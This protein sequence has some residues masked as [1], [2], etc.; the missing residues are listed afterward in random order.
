MIG[1]RLAS[2]TARLVTT[3]ALGALV[4]SPVGCAGGSWLEK[5][6]E[7]DLLIDP[8]SHGYPTAVRTNP[9]VNAKLAATVQPESLP[10]AAA[11]Q[12][13]AANTQTATT[14][15]RSRLDLPPS[16][17]TALAVIPPQLVNRPHDLPTAAHVAETIPHPTDSGLRSA[18][19]SPWL[20]VDS[21]ASFP[22]ASFNPSVT[23]PVLPAGAIGTS[24]LPAAASSETSSQP[25]PESTADRQA[26]IE[27]LQ[28]ELTEALE[29]DIRQRRAGAPGDEE[30]SRLEQRLRLTMLSAGRLDDAV[31]VVESLDK[32]QQE[33]FKNLMFGLGVWLSP[34]EARRAPLRSAKVLR[35]LREATT[36]LS[37]ASK[38]EVRNLAFV[39]Q[40]DHYGG[41]TEFP[42]KEFQPKQEV[43][44]YAEVENFSAEHKAPA[45][46][47]TQLQGSYEIFD[48]SGK[49]I[50]RR[51]LQLDTEICRNYRRDYYLA[52][53]MYMPDNIAPG[54]Y[55]LEL[56]VEDLKAR[57]SYQ[58]RKLGDGVIE[59][60]IR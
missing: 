45:G 47:E 4:F 5:S 48:S 57:G 21:L 9:P 24:V 17:I 8:P 56:T 37:A 6:L 52:Y 19:A 39:Q 22:A 2:N 1:Q 30:L 28:H 13:M 31:S 50:A 34:D 40:V 29:A 43:I 58:G 27:R 38:L 15:Q 23:G 26:R 10:H 36:D 12:A 3:L 33:A 46:Y 18:L 16:P 49:E 25:P 44:L 51:Q 55:R 32:P 53:R 60:T 42:R 14:A 54:H 35:S 20:P 7:T 41:F 11:Q 59:F